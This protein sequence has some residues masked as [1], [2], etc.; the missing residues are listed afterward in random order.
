MSCGFELKNKKKEYTNVFHIIARPRILPRKF[1]I[2]LKGAYSI[3]KW[4]IF[5]GYRNTR[6]NSIVCVLGWHVIPTTML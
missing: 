5:V 1:F 4:F 2:K 3:G 6:E